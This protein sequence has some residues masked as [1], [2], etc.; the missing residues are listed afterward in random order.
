[1][2]LYILDV[3]FYWLACCYAWW[4]LSSCKALSLFIWDNNLLWPWAEASPEFPSSYKYVFCPVVRPWEIS[5]ACC[6]S[7]I[8]VWNLHGWSH[9]HEPTQ[10]E[11]WLCTAY[12]SVRA[13]ECERVKQKNSKMPSDRPGVLFNGFHF[14]VLGQ[15]RSTL[16]LFTSVKKR[17]GVLSSR[18]SVNTQ[19]IN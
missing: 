18:D 8:A 9:Q 7:D 6:W 16:P 2:R 1:M 14:K 11:N 17:S 13:G 4:T 12:M 10:G 5:S 15:E 3:V 19:E